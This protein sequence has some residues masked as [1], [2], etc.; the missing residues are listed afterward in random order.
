MESGPERRIA[1]LLASLTRKIERERD[2]FGHE[3]KNSRATKPASDM[4]K[5]RERNCEKNPVRI[6]SPLLYP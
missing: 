1:S 5:S 4:V 3:R 2:K 6:M